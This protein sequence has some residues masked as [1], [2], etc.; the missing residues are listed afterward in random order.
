MII[1]IKPINDVSVSNS[2]CTFMSLMSS[3]YL[4]CLADP[5]LATFAPN[6]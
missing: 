2:Y 5:V 3:T 6:I 4:L 1:T